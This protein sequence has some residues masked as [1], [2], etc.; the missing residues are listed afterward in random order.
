MPL[1]I[2]F[3]LILLSVVFK[4]LGFFFFFP[5]FTLLLSGSKELCLS[6]YADPLPSFPHPSAHHVSQD[7]TSLLE[8]YFTLY[9]PLSYY[10][11]F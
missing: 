11:D 4:Y 6:S 1:S 7:E 2:K 9:L 8:P 10:Q 3:I 5:V